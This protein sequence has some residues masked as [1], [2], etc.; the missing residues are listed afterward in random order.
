[1][2]FLLVILNPWFDNT[3]PTLGQIPGKKQYYLTTVKAV[4]LREKKSPCISESPGVLSE[5]ADFW[6][7][8]KTYNH[9]L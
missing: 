4:F 7:V 6:D 2:K 8:P 3:L 5:K 9:N 1:M